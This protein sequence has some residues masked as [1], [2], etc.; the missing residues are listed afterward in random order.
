MR[1]QDSI[2]KVLLKDLKTD[3]LSELEREAIKEICDQGLMDPNKT[4]FE[5]IAYFFKRKFKDVME[6]REAFLIYISYLSDNP[7]DIDKKFYLELANEIEI[8]DPNTEQIINC[9]VENKDRIRRI[10]NE[11]SGYII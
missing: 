10:I 6:R 9:I 11:K 2:Y 8:L 4:I 7:Q 5:N 3:E 1:K